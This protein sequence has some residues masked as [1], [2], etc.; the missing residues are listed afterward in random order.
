MNG[1]SKE[2]FRVGPKTVLDWLIELCFNNIKPCLWTFSGSLGLKKWPKREFAG[3]RPKTVRSVS[4]AGIL[5]F[6]CLTLP[7]LVSN[8]QLA[9][10]MQLQGKK[11][12]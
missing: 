4:Q 7:M 1:G 11:R 2:I 3:L 6:G 12:R 10:A 5:C 9:D 8:V